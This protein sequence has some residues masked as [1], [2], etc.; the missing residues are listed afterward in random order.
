MI[1]ASHVRGWEGVQ[2]RIPRTSLLSKA[3]FQELQSS[4]TFCFG[5]AN[6]PSYETWVDKD[7][8]PASDGVD[9]HDRV[10]S[11]DGLSAG[12]LDDTGSR[13]R[14]VESAVNGRERLEVAL[15]WAGERGVERVSEVS[16]GLYQRL[17]TR[18]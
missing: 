5:H 7:R 3:L 11:L 12:N 14:L 18:G 17:I 10:D 16:V 4:I 2:C 9:S 8:L 13:G 6:N 15:V 1:E